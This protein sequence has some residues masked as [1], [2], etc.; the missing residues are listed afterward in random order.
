[1]TA[2]KP[3]HP[4]EHLAEILADLGI[5]Q[6]RLAKTIGVPQIRI[7]DIA[8]CRRSITADTALR[9]GRALGMTPEFW[10]NL[11]RMYDL[12]V[13]RTTTDVGGIKCLT[14]EVRHKTFISYHH[15]D[16]EEVDEFIRTFDH[17][18]DV[19]VARAIG[20]DEAMET[21][22]GS[23]DT[24]YVMRRIREKYLSGTTVTLVFI[25]KDTWAR[26]FVDWELA[27][28]LHQE[29]VSG[30]PN[31]VLAILSPQLTEAILPDRLVDNW[32]SGCAK[33]Y[34]YPNSKTQLTKWIDEVFETR[35]D[36]HKR[37]LITNGRQKLKRNLSPSQ[38]AGRAS[39]KPKP[40]GSH[41]DPNTPAKSAAIATG[42]AVSSSV[43]PKQSSR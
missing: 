11:Q 31:G 8:H 35:E 9:I 3:I 37:T 21:L 30:K 2:I 20:T 36:E 38:P 29:P 26:K 17:D 18:R 22:I 40:D 1:M 14:E 10:L 32:Q 43:P 16:Q 42:S 7:N 34:S 15:A 41:T 5:T 12:D 6:Y 19:F 33:C 27:A 25:G 23:D 13:A 39:V 4:G 24:D 28:S